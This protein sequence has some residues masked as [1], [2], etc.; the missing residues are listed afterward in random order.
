MVYAVPTL[1]PGNREL[2]IFKER[3]LRQNEVYNN[4]FRELDNRLGILEARVIYID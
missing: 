4:R 2:A 1:S 3:V